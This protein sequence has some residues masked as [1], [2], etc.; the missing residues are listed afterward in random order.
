MK[1]RTR[2]G[3]V[4]AASV[5]SLLVVTLS[6]TTSTVAPIHATLAASARL[7]T[8]S[9]NNLII[10]AEATP[11]GPLS[12]NFNPYSPSS[13][14]NTLGGT[15]M[16][17]EPLI[18]YDLMK[19]GVTYPWLATSYTWGN[20]NKTLTFD[21]RHGVDWT[22]GTPFTSADVVYTFNMLQKYPALNSNGI[23][24]TSVTAE[25]PYT[26]VFQ[27][28][29]SA[30]AE[31]FYLAGNTYILPAHIWQNVNPTTYLDTKPVG[32]GPFELKQFTPQ[33]YLLTRNP[34]YWQAGKPAIYGIRFPVY[35]S[36]N[37]A[38]LALEEGQ[39]TWTGNNI[40]GVQKLFVDKS[41]YNVYWSPSN[42]VVALWTNL[43]VAP[44]N[45]YDVREAISLA[46]NREQ[47]S[48]IGEDGTEPVVTNL[49]GIIPT[50]SSYLAPQYENPNLAV[51]GSKAEQL[52]AAAGYKMGGNGV[53]A[54][55]SGKPLDLT[56]VDPAAY[57]DYMTDCAIV[58]SDLAKIGIDVTVQ[59]VAVNAW[60]AD[61]ADGTF[62]ISFR[63]SN[64]PGPS[65]YTQLV[66]WLDSAYS[67]PIGKTA[68]A[69][70]ERWSSPATQKLFASYVDTTSAAV[71]VQDIQGLEAVMV[72]ELPV[73]PL[74]LSPFWG[75]ANESTTT[76][77]PSPSDPYA[78]LSPNAP[79]DEVI[80]LHLM[81]RG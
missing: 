25:G 60:A 24:F 37:A 13:A 69:D 65:P 63:W 22:D 80:A 58:K 42:G 76:G 27:F 1:T 61:L 11:S 81:P 64:G 56:C 78:P 29:T 67:A 36:N 8:A 19:N 31:F 62:Q 33:G 16:I 35:D 23:T 57:E 70:Y 12:D 4:A 20:G 3:K 46:V 75:E 45:S 74:V 2:R 49:A 73:I 26:V 10:S 72:K 50:Y 39:L 68:T 51:N 43:T 17:Y 21:L 6:V 44:L 18:Q 40:I 32:T 59:G 7:V 34:A 52:L 41:K 30:Y 15:G 77:W 48:Q 53:M 54:N 79:V 47:I 14:G 5:A 38:N 71:R 9:S 66:G 55:S 28:P